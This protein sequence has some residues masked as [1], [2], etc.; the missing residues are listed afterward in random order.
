MQECEQEGTAEPIQA[1][2]T[3]GLAHLPGLA[4]LPGLGLL[5]VGRFVQGALQVF[6]QV[7][8]QVQGVVS[9]FHFQAVQGAL[10]RRKD[11]GLLQDVTARGGGVCVFVGFLVSFSGT[12]L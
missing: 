7:A 11:L 8:L 6:V 5:P 9:N 4:L 2:H 3:Q 1:A 10:L 12:A